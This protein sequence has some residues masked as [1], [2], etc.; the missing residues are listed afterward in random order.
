VP[1]VWW[2]QFDV[3]TA[4]RGADPAADFE[5]FDFTAHDLGAYD[6]IWMFAVESS[7]NTP[8]SGAENAAVADFMEGGGGVFAT[9]DHEDLGV[10]MCGALPRVRSMRKWHW[11][12]PG[13]NGEPVAPPVGGPDRLDTLSAGPTAG[14]QF[15]DQSDAIP[16]TIAPRLYSSG[17][18]FPHFFRRAHPHPVLCGP[19][20]PI[21]VLPD[22]PHEG[23]CY[24]PSNLAAPFTV[25]GKPFEEYPALPS[26][27]R[28]AP[29]ILA[30]SHI[31][32]LHGATD[33][34]GPVNPRTFGAIGGW[35]G[36]RVGRGRVIVDATWHHFFNINLVGDASSPTPEKRLAFLDASA[37][38]AVFEQLQAYFRN[39]AVWLARPQRQTC[40]RRG[41]LWA[42]RVDHRFLM[43]LRAEYFEEFPKRLDLAELL[44][45][46]DVARDVLGRLA[47]HCEVLTFRHFLV[48]ELLPKVYPK[49]EPWIDPWWPHPPKPE[50]DPNP[51]V[52]A[53]MLG[54]AV[55]GAALYAVGAEFGQPGPNAA[56]RL[57]DI[58]EW[59]D[60][61][62]P[63]AEQALREVSAAAERSGRGLEGLRTSLRPKGTSRGN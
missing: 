27:A 36:H 37:D 63:A 41:G 18:S 1:P 12:N 20:G 28:L 4:H 56:G 62:R 6:Q 19:R 34:K 5:S 30:T 29:E 2:V 53:D 40:M 38:P 60:L 9:G 39:I 33:I 25:D 23:E 11:P 22:H 59:T 15:D 45:A 61:L 32:G 31:R 8:L 14:I 35:D 24:V 42:I 17:P 52:F 26:G 46:G 51:W 7:F 55:L 49:L 58:E 57:Q 13:P 50:P 43:D 3:T 44:R 48:K 47:S 16:Q 10:A 54:D 21:R